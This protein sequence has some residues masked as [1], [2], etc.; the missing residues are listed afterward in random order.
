L[1]FTKIN[2]KQTMAGSPRLPRSYRFCSG[3]DRS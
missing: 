1:G 3:S 2:V